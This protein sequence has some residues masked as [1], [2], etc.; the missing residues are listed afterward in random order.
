MPGRRPLSRNSSTRSNRIM[1]FPRLSPAHLD[2]S[3]MNTLKPTTA[4]S[5]EICKSS[6]MPLVH[7]SGLENLSTTCNFVRVVLISPSR[8]P[9]TPQFSGNRV[10]QVSGN[11]NSF[12]LLTKPMIRAVSSPRKIS[13]S[14]SQPVSG[15]YN[16]ICRRCGGR[17][18]LYQPGARSRISD[19]LYLIKPGSSYFTSKG[20]EYTEIE[21]R[22]W[23]TGDSSER[24]ISGFTKVILLSERGYTRLQIREITNL[25]EKVIDEYLTLYA[26]YKEIGSDRIAQI[27]SSSGKEV[28]SKKRGR[29]ESR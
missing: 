24:Y 28:D 8:I 21:Q 9:R 23:H 17:V 6:I 4:I 13:P 27:L 19:L 11:I 5:G 3:C 14:S 2:I 18:V 7:M 20:Y 16:V 25:S 29:E 12:G 1:V 15:L 26:T 10:L 22:T